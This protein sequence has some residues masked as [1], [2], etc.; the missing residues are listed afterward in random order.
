MSSP[1]D[2]GKPGQGQDSPGQPWPASTGT[3]S[4]DQ[5]TIAET[6]SPD[7]SADSTAR[8]TSGAETGGESSS[9]SPAAPPYGQQSGSGDAPHWQTPPRAA[10]YGSSGPVTGSQPTPYPPEGGGLQP[11]PGA[12]DYTDWGGQ[13]ASSS[14]PGSQP[15]YG[16]SGSPSTGSQPAA[17]ESDPVTG[18]QAAWGQPGGQQQY[19]TPSF[20]QQSPPTGYSGS[21]YPG[22]EYSSGSYQAIPPQTAGYA[23][24]T[25]PS[26]GQGAGNAP[27]G[28][29]PSGNQYGNQPSGQYGNQP[30][31]NQYGSPQSGPPGSEA[32][33]NY[34]G[35]YGPQGGASPYGSSP[36][37]GQ[38]YGSAGQQGSSGQGYPPS[39]YQP[40]TA[41]PAQPGYGQYGNAPTG[42]YDPSVQSGYGGQGYGPPQHA[43]AS[44]VSSGYDPAA[45]QGQT[46]G[47]PQ[48]SYG[49]Q[50]YG[51]PSYSETQYGQSAAYGA[52]TGSYAAATPYGQQTSPA[53]EEKKRGGKAGIL[54][55]GVLVVL[56]GLAAVAL[57]LWPGF[58]KKT[59]LDEQRLSQDVLTILVTEPPG[60][61]GQSGTESVTCPANQSIKKGTTFTCTATIDGEQTDVRIEVTGDETVESEKGNYQV[62]PP[63]Q[64]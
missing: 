47:Y 3:P 1:N 31:G 39:G 49:Q 4:W 40:T 51:Q 6:N 17:G 37:Y 45:R 16:T 59:V 5:P 23:G 56:L 7:D 62:F 48:Q 22:G 9:G 8:E 21:G 12:S 25:S 42:S 26:Y 52:P 38:G 20:G 55:A 15:A 33:P 35:Q 58:L 2:P 43:G 60:G 46:G 13:R 27:Y 30:S 10:A 14:T 53:A 11:A 57:F 29:S 63:I 36:D 50:S 41:Q 64:E 61:Y 34:G 32:P 24:E 19:G 28:G 54:V 18:S 44:P